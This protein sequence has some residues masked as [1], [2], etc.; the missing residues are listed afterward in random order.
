VVVLGASHL[1]HEENPAFVDD[2]IVGFVARRS[3]RQ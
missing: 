1:M 2:A 3:S